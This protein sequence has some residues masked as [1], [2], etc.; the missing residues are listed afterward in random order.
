MKK[1]RGGGPR[2]A[3]LDALLLLLAAACV[4]LVL[5]GSQRMN[6]RRTEDYAKAA[7]GEAQVRAARELGQ[8]VYDDLRIKVRKTLPG[9]V[10]WGDGSLT[11]FDGRSL[12]ET[13]AK[14]VPEHVYGAL[15]DL[16]VEK[17]GLR[18]PMSGISPVFALDFPGEDLYAL[19]ARNGVGSIRIGESFS[20]P[21]STDPVAVSLMDGEGH[22]LRFN[23]DHNLSLG[24]VRV[25]GVPGYFYPGSQAS[26]PRGAALAFGRELAGDPVKAATGLPVVVENVARYQ[27]CLPLIF[28][29]EQADM[30]VEDQVSAIRVILAA[31]DTPGSWG[32]VICATA[33]DGPLDAALKA[34]FGERYIRYDAVAF[35]NVSS[36]ADRVIAYLE[37]QGAFNDAYGAAADAVIALEAGKP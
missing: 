9:I 32:L 16:F 20:I 4:G 15:S 25:A 30:P 24:R 37:L 5:L 27:R 13:L 34:A 10:C 35:P 2:R 7:R 17:A 33:Q 31:H 14:S 3:A 21:G 11:A 26:N 12:P 29:G 6:V 36:L 8:T 23:T 1:K 28:V 18:F 19:A 22:T